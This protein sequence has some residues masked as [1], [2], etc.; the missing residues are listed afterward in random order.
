M[1]L[2]ISLLKKQSL[3]SCFLHNI[4]KLPDSFGS[5]KP[6]NVKKTMDGAMLIWDIDD[7]VGGEER[8]ISYKVKA[9]VNVIGKLKIP[10]ALCRYRKGKRAII[11]KS[12]STLVF[13]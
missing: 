13:S 5:L 12:N 8:V 7:I 10:R 3:N 4:T 1:H 6:T 11:V 2:I 9:G